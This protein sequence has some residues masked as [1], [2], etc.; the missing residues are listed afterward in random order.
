[1]DMQDRRGMLDVIGKAVPGR[2]IEI[3]DDPEIPAIDCCSMEYGLPDD[4]FG[5][6][7][8]RYQ[9]SA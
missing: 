3:S 2:S 1:M 6:G 5:S 7:S 8:S 9:Q 4:D